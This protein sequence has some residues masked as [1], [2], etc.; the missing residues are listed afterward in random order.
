[1]LSWLAAL[2]GAI[3]DPVKNGEGISFGLI[4]ALWIAPTAAA[5]APCIFLTLVLLR[6]RRPDVREQMHEDTRERGLHHR[7]LIRRGR[8]DPTDPARRNEPGISTG[9]V[10]EQAQHLLLA[11]MFRHRRLRSIR[12]AGTV[13]GSVVGASAA[14]VG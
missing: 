3:V 4:F 5:T 12:S 9:V 14:I 7:E 8:L 2:R 6:L 10:V 1:M 11:G 13:F